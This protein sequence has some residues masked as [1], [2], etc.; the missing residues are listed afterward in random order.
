[1]ITDNTEELAQN[2]LI[3]LYIIDKSPFSFSK[4]KLNEFILEKN[5][6]NYFFLQ[7]YLSELVNS[8]FIS[9]VEEDEEFKYIITEQGSL[10]L[11]CFQNKV[12][13]KLKEDLETEFESIKSTAKKEAQVA[14]EYYAREDGQYV[15]NIKLVENEDVLFSLYINVATMEHAKMVCEN[16]KNNPNEIYSDIVNKLITY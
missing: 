1:M 14:A 2:K 15:A 7:Q 6:M 16:W 9:L 4:K 8:N 11:D 5:Y 12:P 10:V 13:A 3:L